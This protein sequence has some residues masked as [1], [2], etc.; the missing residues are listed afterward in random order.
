MLKSILYDYSFAYVPVKKSV[1]V[2]NTAARD[3]DAKIVSKN[4]IFENCTG[5]TD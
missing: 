5:F 3:A 1:S 4:E 2:T